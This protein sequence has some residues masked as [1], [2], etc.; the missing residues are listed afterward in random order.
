MT[1]KFSYNN[2]EFNSFEEALN[3]KHIDTGVKTKMYQ[4]ISSMGYTATS[5]KE[6]ENFYFERTGK[7]LLDVNGILDTF[8]KLI[9]ADEKTL[10]EEAGHLALAHS[11]KT[12][13]YER[14]LELV[15]ET[16]E[17]K[18]QAEAYKEKYKEINKKS[19]IEEKVRREIIGQLIGKQL[20]DSNN[21]RFEKILQS[22]WSY[23]KDLFVN[24][25]NEL[26]HFVNQISKAVND[27]NLDFFTTQPQEKEIYFNL[28]PPVVERISNEEQFLRGIIESTK[29]RIKKLR[30]RGTLEKTAR[31][32][33]TELSDYLHQIENKEYKIGVGKFVENLDRDL[34][35]AVDHVTQAKTKTTLPNT[36]TVA[37]LGDFINYYKPALD[38]LRDQINANDISDLDYLLP[39]IKKQIEAF[40]D[41]NSYYKSVQFKSTVAIT[42]SL[43]VELDFDPEV[44]FKE[45]G[46][47]VN[48]ITYLYGSLRDV[49]D[50]ILRTIYASVSKILNKVRRI[51]YEEGKQ[52]VKFVL[53]TKKISDTSFAAEKDSKGKTTGYFITQYRLAEF[54]KLYNEFKESLHTRFNII[55]GQEIADKIQL[56]EYNKIFNKWKSDNVERRFIPE[57]YN[58]R[59]NLSISTQEAIDEANLAIELLLDKY[60]KEDLTVDLETIS[61]EDWNNLERL[62]IN[63]KNL[64]NEYDDTGTKK[65]GIDLTIALELKEFNEKH[66]EFIQYERVTEKFEE[67]RAVK[68]RTLTPDAYK[69]WYQRNTEVTY[70]PEF[71]E[72]L[73]RTP[74]DSAYED[75]LKE[76][77]ELLKTYRVD[78]INVV[79][80]HLPIDVQ[81]KVKRLDSRIANFPNKN[82]E[83]KFHEYAT[84]EKTEEYELAKQKA[85]ADGTYEK[86][87]IDNHFTDAKGY[88]KPYSFWTK[89]VPIDK[90]YIKRQPSKEWSEVSP[91][92]PWLNRAY[93]PTWKGLQPKLSKW[94]NKEF[95]KL[96]NDQKEVLDFLIKAKQKGDERMNLS[97]YNAHMLPQISQSFMDAMYKGSDLLRSF[98]ELI[99]ESVQ[100]RT[101]DDIIFGDEDNAYRFDGTKVNY[102]ARRHTKMLDNPDTISRDILSSTIL[103]NE[104]S[105]H[106]EQMTKS[107]PDL[108]LLQ[109]QIGNRKFKSKRKIVQG[110]ETNLAKMSRSFLDANVYG[111]EFNEGTNIPIPEIKIWGWKVPLTGSSVNSTKIVSNLNA[112]IRHNNLIA[113]FFSMSANLIGGSIQTNVETIIGRYSSVPARLAAEKEFFSNIHKV[114][115]EYNQPNKQNKMQLMLEKFGASKDNRALFDDLDKEKLL[116]LTP[117]DLAYVGW[118][119]GGYYI[120]AKT[121]LSILFNHRY[122]PTANKFITHQ[123]FEKQ[124]KDS[125][126]EFN[127]LI[128]LYDMF[129]IVNGQP[130]VKAIHKEKVSED[131]LD[132]I[133]AL[134]AQ[135]IAIVDGQVSSI[136]RAVAHRNVW[137]A[138]TT[139]HRGWLIDG[140]ARRFKPESKNLATDYTE[141]GYHRYFGRFLLDTVLKKEKLLN[142][143]FA[144]DYYHTLES[145]QKEAVLK[146]VTEIAIVV[147]MAIVAKII[148]NMADDDQE[149]EM[150]FAAY[151]SNRLLLELSA[152]SPTPLMLVESLQIISSPIAGT[153]QLETLMDIADIFSGK[154]IESG[155]FEGKTKREKF[156]IRMIPGIK[157]YYSSFDPDSSNEFLKNKALRWLY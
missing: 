10:N 68:Q 98:K 154:E 134:I 94:N 146:S 57:Y 22:L 97:N 142:L 35:R 21:T 44:A 51:S 143:K 119:Q 140:L 87:K 2:K 144:F 32:L 29:L 34:S 1:C 88:I 6:Y 69:R 60:R 77:R 92:S 73:E 84:V 50:P 100:S 11:L 55:Q 18:K 78:G 82:I 37:N 3:S 58:L 63:R 116:R 106:Y 130:Q 122:D 152:L 128:S 107:A 70:D 30:E 121:A 90:R 41:I 66:F 139:T 25:K 15:V 102:V 135:R 17:Y 12:A 148:N 5:L 53:Q 49:T 113:N 52:F 126:L 46:K 141:V 105:H 131:L 36:K 96:T 157:G 124:Y 89:I 86:W 95:D 9:V 109:E 24:R 153:R 155:K 4:F 132:K 28:T 19:E 20:V 150:E 72:L 147:A 111:I 62:K 7:K 74:G 123:V 83:S 59:N 156:L 110:K 13:K 138:L 40:N 45:P 118:E 27:N 39:T 125:G 54:Y 133:M 101:D 56:V 85:I 75:L 136:D 43:G 91:D 47:D 71:Y 99:K 65:S 137:W 117:S 14:A 120:K 115:L 108:E 104:W 151:L 67:T 38:Q 80:K 16:P 33:K 81:N 8:N 149:P 79:V 127:N 26:Q 145:H 112:Y 103:Y 64:S 31:R 93:D 48:Q 129:D 114:I 61:E 23:F 76:R 42:N